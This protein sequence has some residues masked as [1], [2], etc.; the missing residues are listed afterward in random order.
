MGVPQMYGESHK[1]GL[2]RDTPVSGNLHILGIV[3]IQEP[4]I[5]FSSKQDSME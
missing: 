3:I 2:V 1:H 5:P 4:G